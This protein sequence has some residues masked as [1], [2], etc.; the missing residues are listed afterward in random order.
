MKNYLSSMKNYSSS[1]RMLSYGENMVF[2]SADDYVILSPYFSRLPPL[3]MNHMY[4]QRPI[5]SGIH[6][7]I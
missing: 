5:S 1:M 6:Q 7:L 4:K 2:N 3:L